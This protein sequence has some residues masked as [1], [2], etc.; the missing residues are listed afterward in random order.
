MSILFSFLFLLTLLSDL[1]TTTLQTNSVT[2]YRNLGNCQKKVDGS[3]CHGSLG[4]PG[5]TCARLR[6]SKGHSYYCVA[7]KT[8]DFQFS[9]EASYSPI[10]TKSRGGPGVKK[11]FIR[12]NGPGL[13]WTKSIEMRKAA[14]SLYTWSTDIQYRSNSEALSCRTPS[15]CSFNQGALEFRIYSDEEA[16]NGMQG[17]NFYIP[18][19]LTGSLKGSK[20]FI[21]PKVSVYPWFNTVKSLAKPVSYTMQSDTLNDE[22][23]VQATLVYPPSFRENSLKKYP[24]VIMLEN[25][26][27]YIP[28]F[29]YLFV[30]TGLVEE[31]L[32]VIVK[33]DALLTNTSH[34]VLPFDTFRLECKS[35]A[36]CLRCQV[37][38]DAN[39]TEPCDREEFILRSKRCLY[40][41][42]RRGS[43][44]SLLTEIIQGMAREV[45]RVTE[46]RVL[47]DPPRERL[48]LI[49]YGERAVAV[50]LMGLS[51]PDLI[52][53]V[54]AISPQFYLPIA[55][56]YSIKSA[57]LRHM[58]DLALKFSERGGQ[59][60]LYSS[61][62]YYISHGESDNI[63][64]PP[65]KTISLTQ[66]VIERL[67][68][69]FQMEDGVNI[70]FQITPEK[71]MTYLPHH[72][73]KLPILSHIKPLM[74]YF[75]KAEGGTS[76]IKA[77]NINSF[78]DYLAEARKEMPTV[79]PSDDM[80]TNDSVIEINYRGGLDGGLE[81]IRCVPSYQEVPL[82]VFIG[83]IGR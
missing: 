51:R 14:R 40:F 3:R 72:E 18:L 30:H 81:I 39:R 70:M 33:P 24:I 74:M 66:E 55:S 20:L 41:K 48:T 76:K 32:V 78:K 43:S 73:P 25:G 37:C 34:S 79:A 61:Q 80:A 71:T 13:S 53:N 68:E 75:H 57:V 45:R 62:K 69:K 42:H 4:E 22:I 6:T 15:H 59:Q 7:P 60:L 54:A 35:M 58:D 28:Q 23:T 16:L 52:V 82:L 2:Y 83:S 36:D 19:P 67:K 49:G 38:W 29:E 12:G 44:E 1:I 46:D 50:F 77:L 27:H 56:D 9:I 26:E 17:P 64:F 21:K 10:T 5:G 31:A 65:A 47:F 11:M 63:R 8:Q